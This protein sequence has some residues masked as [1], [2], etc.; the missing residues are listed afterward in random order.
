MVPPD[1]Y[2]RPHAV[3]F[4]C[5]VIDNPDDDAPR[6][7]FADWL[8]DNGDAERAE[9]I[10]LQI[11]R[12]KLPS[13]SLRSWQILRR[14]QQLEQQHGERWRGELAAITSETTFRRGFVEGVKLGVRQF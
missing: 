7:I 8:D 14:E 2:A 4:L 11:E 6:L 9:F 5:D 12:D 1:L 3:A 13:H 10:R